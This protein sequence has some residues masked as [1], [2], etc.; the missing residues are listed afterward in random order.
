VMGMQVAPEAGVTGLPRLRRSF[1]VALRRIQVQ[2]YTWTREGET[3]A[4]ARAGR[5]RPP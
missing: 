1:R 5:N 2:T 3:T 4:A